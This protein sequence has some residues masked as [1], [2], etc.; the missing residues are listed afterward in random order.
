MG[1]NDY[2]NNANIVCPFFIMQYKTSIQC[3]GMFDKQKN[4]NL[5]FYN[6]LAKTEYIN[7]FCTNNCYKGC[8]VAIAILERLEL[9]DEQKS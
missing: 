8:P 7:N 1:L 4:T 6:K 3:Q 2:L 5:C 9:E